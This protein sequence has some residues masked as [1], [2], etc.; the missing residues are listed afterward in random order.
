MS[1]RPSRGAG[2]FELFVTA[3]DIANSTQSLTY[4]FLLRMARQNIQASK[5]VPGERM[6]NFVTRLS[7]LAELCEY[8]EE[9][10]NMTRDKMT[11]CVL[12]H[13]KDKYLKSKLYRR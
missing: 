4:H 8:V 5:P 6:N 9:K 7:S 3:L 10:D 12:A 2:E 13:I 1:L 11:R